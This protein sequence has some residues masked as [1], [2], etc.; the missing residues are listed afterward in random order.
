MKITANC[1]LVLLLVIGSTATAQQPCSGP[2]TKAVVD[3]PQFRS[4]PCHTGFN[5]Y[6]FV[7]GPATVGNLVLDWTYNAGPG[8]AYSSPAVANGVVYV[9]SVE[10]DGS[11][12]A[13]NANTGTLRWRYTTGDDFI[14]SP[15]VANGVVYVGCDD[16]NLYALNAS[17]GTL[18]WNHTMGYYVESSPTVA[19]GVVYVGSNEGNLWALN[20]STGALLWRYGTGLIFLSSPAMANGVVY[21]GS[22]TITCER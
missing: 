11:L 18:L 7:L 8:I 9:G 4:D 2:H 22:T 20:A 12:Y 16:H 19:N 21:V 10:P 17:T 5:P 1:L 13:I 6:E 14:S 3:W 15:A